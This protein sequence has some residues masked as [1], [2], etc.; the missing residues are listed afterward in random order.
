[1]GRSTQLLSLTLR[2]KAQIFLG[3]SSLKAFR[4][5]SN[6]LLCFFLHL[7]IFYFP[8]QTPCDEMAPGAGRSAVQGRGSAG[9][10]AQ[11]PATRSGR[12][13]PA[14]LQTPTLHPGQHPSSYSRAACSSCMFLSPKQRQAALCRHAPKCRRADFLHQLCLAATLLPS[15]LSSDCAVW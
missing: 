10:A 15:L 4:N 8:P 2:V 9:R 7:C 11:A 12:W 1:M 14:G 6:S 13:G 3:T 5:I